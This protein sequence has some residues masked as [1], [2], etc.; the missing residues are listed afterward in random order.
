ML[1]VT[2]VKGPHGELLAI[3]VLDSFDQAGVTFFTEAHHGQQVGYMRHPKGHSI[4]PH[5]H[6]SLQRTIERTQEVLYVKKGLVALRLFTEDG[7]P[8]HSC[9]L[10]GGDLVALISGGHSLEFLE[11]S[12]LIET[13][14]GPFMGAA[15]KA[16]YGQS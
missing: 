6:R 10:R 3:I 9:Q 13:K 4:L 14:S 16:L 5:S 8:W 11:E 1:P 7:T 12:I 15:D 2:E